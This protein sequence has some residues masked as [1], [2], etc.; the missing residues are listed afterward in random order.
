MT[1]SYRWELQDL[2][3]AGRKALITGAAGSLGGAIA[4]RFAEEG[5]IVMLADVLVQKA[6]AAADRLKDKGYQAEAVHLNVTDEEA[7]KR[8]FAEIAELDVLV[9]N[10]GI[11]R[12]GFIQELTVRD[13]NEMLNINLTSVFLCSKYALPLLKQSKSPAIVNMSSINAFYMSPGLPAYSAAKSGMIALTEQLALEGA[14]DRIRA[15]CISPGRTMSEENQNKRADSPGFDIELDSYPL[16][17]LGYPVD[18][19]NAALFLASDLSAFVN[20]VNLV[21]DGGMSLQ[22]VSGLIRPDLRRRW[23]QGVYRL[24]M[25]E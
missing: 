24:E 18:V 2:L 21:V 22:S 20:G 6:E 9:N 19:A 13:W 5:C 23:K 8:V 12:S 16:G 15:N 3:L 14:A 1:F 17:R 4:E 25:E 7:V 10:A 11:T